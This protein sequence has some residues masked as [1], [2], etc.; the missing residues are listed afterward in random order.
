MRLILALCLMVLV[1]G[2]GTASRAQD[3]GN[4]PTR[5]LAP[6]GQ[7]GPPRVV[8]TTIDA[9]TGRPVA[10]SL[11]APDGTRGRSDEQGRF[12]LRLP[13]GTEGELVAETEDGRRG[14]VSLRPLVGGELEVVVHLRR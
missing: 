11:T 3:G 10:A 6:A 7:A 13:L 8:G 5:T 2:C 4:A 1:Q 12:Q 14:R 9:A